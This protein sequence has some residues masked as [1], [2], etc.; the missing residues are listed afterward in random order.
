MGIRDGKHA[1]RWPVLFVRCGVYLVI[2]GLVVYAVTWLSDLTLGK[3]DRANVARLVA[4]PAF[5]A[6]L[7]VV[8]DV[9]RDLKRPLKELPD[10]DREADSSPG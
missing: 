10:L 8:H 9:R 4:I 1:I 2:F 5:L 3:H 6:I 7:F